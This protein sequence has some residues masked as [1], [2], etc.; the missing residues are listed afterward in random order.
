MHMQIPHEQKLNVI[1]CEDK[2]LSQFKFKLIT[3][4]LSN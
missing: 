2:N 1:S 4:W 3:S